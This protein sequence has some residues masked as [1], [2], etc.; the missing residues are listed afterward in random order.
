MD[1][2]A[3]QQPMKHSQARLVGEEDDLGSREALAGSMSV[4]IGAFALG[5]LAVSL[6][7]L[8]FAANAAADKAINEGE[9][10][11]EQDMEEAG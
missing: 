7:I 8:G 9:P 1:D 5:V 10:V 3:Y 6:L 4:G 11:H 2:L